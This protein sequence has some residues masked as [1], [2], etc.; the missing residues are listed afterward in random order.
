MTKQGQ[1]DIGSPWMSFDQVFRKCMFLPPCR[2]DLFLRGDTGAKAANLRNA[3]H[4]R[5]RQFALSLAFAAENTKNLSLTLR[6]RKK[7]WAR[8]VGKSR[9][10]ETRTVAW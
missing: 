4:F 2:H 7:I 6:A 1:R 8:L 5:F 10:T 9:K 3:S